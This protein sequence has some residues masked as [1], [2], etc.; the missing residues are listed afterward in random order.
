MALTYSE[1][2]QIGM[3][4]PQF[5]SE[6]LLA[7]NNVRQHLSDFRYAKALVI[8][9]MC[10]HCPYVKA[11]QGR[12][13]QLAKDFKN[14]KVQVIGINSNDSVRYPDDSFEAMKK[15]V[16]EQKFEFP[17][18]WDE[19]QEVARAYGAVCTP[20]FFVFENTQAEEFREAD[21][22]TE[23]EKDR[24]RFVLRYRGRLDDN[25]KDESQVTR[26]DL[27]AALE[28]ILAGRLYNEEQVPSMG[29]SIKWKESAER[30]TG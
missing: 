16:A 11:V 18:L 27:A 30:K 29:C 25:W 3:P 2:V 10:N 20:D 23:R 1:P 9:F 19:T 7:T 28:D 12:I 5:P 26:R 13:N 21:L 4:A 22:V 24:D 8:V 15:Q 17:Y 14:R 6:G